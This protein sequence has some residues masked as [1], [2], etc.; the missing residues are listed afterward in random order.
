MTE[1]MVIRDL[2]RKNPGFTKTVYEWS[3]DKTASTQDTSA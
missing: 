2:Q 1:I 3:A